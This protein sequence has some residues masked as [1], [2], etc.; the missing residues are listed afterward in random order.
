MFLELLQLALTV[1]SVKTR[2]AKINAKCSIIYK[3][4]FK[5]SIIVPVSRK[6]SFHYEIYETKE[7][8][9]HLDLCILCYKNIYFYFSSS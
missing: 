3:D 7:D 1:R 5:L 2:D 9:T 6:H 4:S 8:T